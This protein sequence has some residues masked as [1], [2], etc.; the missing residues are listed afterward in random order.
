MLVN[1]QLCCSLSLSNLH[2]Q[3]Y[4]GAANMSEAYCVAQAFVVEQQSI[5]PHVLCLSHSLNCQAQ[6]YSLL[7]R[8]KD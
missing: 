7:S 2:D 8:R 5:V 6:Q 1:V 3:M 4:D